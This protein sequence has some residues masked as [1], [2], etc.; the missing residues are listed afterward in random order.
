MPA[1]CVSVSRGDGVNT[2][3]YAWLEERSGD[4][5]EVLLTAFL[6]GV[7][8][9][10]RPHRAD[11]L[12]IRLAIRF[13]FRIARA[14]GAIR[15]GLVR[16]VDEEHRFRELRA[17]CERLARVEGPDSH[18]CQLDVILLECWKRVAS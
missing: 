8:R 7:V 18:N 4:G 14:G 5:V 11:A 17:R 2:L 6:E 12:E 1:V 13:S 10:L 3:R 9:G 16:I 15:L